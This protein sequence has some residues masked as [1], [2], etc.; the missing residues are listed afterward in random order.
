M[1]QCLPIIDQ[2]IN[3]D[4]ASTDACKFKWRDCRDDA[5]YNL[6]QQESLN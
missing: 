1:T 3:D 4:A 5:L 6:V 2:N